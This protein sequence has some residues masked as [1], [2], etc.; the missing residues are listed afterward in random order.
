MPAIWLPLQRKGAGEHLQPSR[1][2]PLHL[3]CHNEEL[4]VD[5]YQEIFHAMLFLGADP[6]LQSM[7]SCTHLLL[8]SRYRQRG[9]L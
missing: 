2:D 6:N 4:H 5:V 1:I 7:T 9:C 8:S 3:L